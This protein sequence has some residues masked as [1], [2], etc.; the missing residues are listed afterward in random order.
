M[1]N[2]EHLTEEGLKAITDIKASL[3]RGLSEELNTIFPNTIPVKRPVV[4]QIIPDPQWLAGFTTAEGNFFLN[5]YKANTKMGVG[6]KLVFRITQHMRD[7]SLMKIFILYLD[8]GKVYKKSNKDAVDFMVTGFSDITNK[9]IPFLCEYP[10]LG[11]KSEDFKD[12]CIIAELMKNKKHLTK[13]GIKEI[14]RIKA[15]MNTG[16]EFPSN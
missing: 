11:K 5:I 10:I 6:I 13:E 3:N 16:R 1:K 7:E 12:F 15:G 4:N 14:L 8:C 2:K 9:I